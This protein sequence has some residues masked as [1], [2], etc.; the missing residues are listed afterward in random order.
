M[1]IIQLSP[2]D[3]ALCAL[4]ILILAGLSFYSRLGIARQLLVSALRT[5]VQLML[6]GVVLKAVFDNAHPGWLLLISTVMLTVAGYEVMARQ[7]HPL[8][9]IWSYGISLF[10]MFLSSFVLVLF[11]LILVVQPEP[12]YQPQYSIPLLGM[13][14]GNTMNGVALAV[15][16]L[17]SSIKQNRKIVEGKLML[18]WTSSQAVQDI[19][20]DSV[21]TG[22]I[23]IINAMAAA[24]IVSLPGMMTGQ[25]L[26]GA[27]PMESVKYQILIM[28]LIAAGTGY[29]TMVAVKMTARR[30]FD[31]RHRLHLER[32]KG[33]KKS[34]H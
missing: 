31:G 6:V 17:T 26:A 32:L 21:R 10:S 19:V 2:L 20:R 9:G 14:L 3:L 12:W 22:L 8:G 4:L 25:I 29:A 1:N 15:D 5:V 28:F 18:G 30:L 23:P 11:A 13:L 34:R 7:R 27:P 24:G 16:H 33:L